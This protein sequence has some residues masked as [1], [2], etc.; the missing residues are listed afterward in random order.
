MAYYFYD[1]EAGWLEIIS[2]EF[3]IT[4]M[5]VTIK[6]SLGWTEDYIMKDW[7]TKP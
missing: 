4:G 7:V 1:S 3:P 6:N 5:L 2:T